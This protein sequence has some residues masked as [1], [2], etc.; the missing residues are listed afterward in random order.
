MSVSDSVVG[1]NAH[2]ALTFAAIQ[3]ERYDEAAT[4]GGIVDVRCSG[5]ARMPEPHRLVSPV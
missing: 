1:F 2:M 5:Y 4:H 3:E